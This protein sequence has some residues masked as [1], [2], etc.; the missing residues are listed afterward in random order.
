MNEQSETKK[1]ERNNEMSET[2]I[3]KN[4]DV[5]YETF[6]AWFEDDDGNS[7]HDISYTGEYNNGS[8][9]NV[10]YRIS[11]NVRVVLGASLEY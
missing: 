10:S 6:S 2:V 7:Y 3:V 11:G 8:I 5:D 4:L 9:I 1:H